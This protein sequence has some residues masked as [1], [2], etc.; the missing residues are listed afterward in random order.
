MRCLGFNGIN[1]AL[2]KSD[3]LS[4]SILI[5]MAE[6]DKQNIE[7]ERYLFYRLSQIKP[8]L[9]G[10]IMDILVKTLDI[11]PTISLERKVRMAD[12]VVW[13]EAISQAMGNKPGRYAEILEA[14]QNR[15]HV[16]AV[17]SNT[18][19]KLYDKIL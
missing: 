1:I 19:R 8:Q 15:Q 9:L 18:S 3:S 2:T 6:I 13:G 11:Y 10:Y 14:N 5:E 7:E 12:Y 4:R 17:L 16:T